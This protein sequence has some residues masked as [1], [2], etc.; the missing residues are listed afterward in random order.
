MTDFTITESNISNI[1]SELLI[2]QEILNIA[3]KQDLKNIY[4]I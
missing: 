3:I 1:L 2:E 4:R